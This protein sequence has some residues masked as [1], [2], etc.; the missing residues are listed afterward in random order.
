MD[1]QEAQTSSAVSGP[2]SV[3]VTNIGGIDQCSI[4]LKPGVNVLVGRNAT[5]RTSFLHAV[6][7]GLG[8][9]KPNLK[10]DA[11][12]GLVTLKADN[13]QY[14]R[15]QYRRNDTI[16]VEGNGYTT[17]SSLVDLFVATLEENPV[18]S[19][20]R[21]GDNLREI[22]MDPIDTEQINRR[23]RDLRR[24]KSDLES[25][26]QKVTQ[27][28]S[29]LPKL[30]E[31]RQ[32]LKSELESIDQ[33][34]E[35]HR[36]E[37]SEY[38]SDLDQTDNTEL[39]NRLENRRQQLN[40]A[41]DR[42]EVL[43][44]ELK[45]LNEKRDSLLEDEESLSG[46]SQGDLDQ[47]QRDLRSLRQ[48]KRELEGTISDLTTIV[49][50]N[51]NLIEGETELPDEVH[52]SDTT[53]DQLAPEEDRPVYCWTCG[54]ETT[55]GSIKS[56]LQSLRQIV[57]EKRDDRTS[58]EQ[59]INELQAEEKE[60]RKA[61]DKQQSIENNIDQTTRKI[62]EKENQVDQTRDRITALKDEVATLEKQVA[63]VEAVNED[64]ALEIHEK[65]SEL[66]YQRGQ[67]EEN[68]QR[69]EEDI[70]EIEALPDEEEILDQIG[71]IQD[72]LEDERARIRDIENEVV[73]EFNNHM[74]VILE[75]LDYQNIER[76][77]IERH[78]RDAEDTSSTFELHIVRTDASG[79][80]YEDSIENL[81]ESE[82]E[83]IGLILALAGFLAHEVYKDV[84]FILLDS[85]EAIDATRITN[86]VEYFAK[87]TEYL[88]VA[89]LPEDAG[90]ITGEANY[91]SADKLS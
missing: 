28:R 53:L 48:K 77:W 15:Q 2:L 50:F 82:R 46:R 38:Q 69:V 72:Q 51:D 6:A 71:Q 86:L 14:A 90:D 85:L 49:D 62:R 76:V 61:I 47:V 26:Q 21:R 58:I 68:L 17:K 67:V 87:Y 22:I 7:S 60:I 80:G 32:K 74:D 39:V 20:A 63:D 3:D 73:E 33:Q 83:V 43:E 44:A 8:G 91:I 78:V 30:E 37:L 57:Q 54:S 81:S 25:Q 23:I 70:N 36:T 31:R 29:Q 11:T 45:A 88:I 12:E 66:Q 89:L 59:Q 4:I 18:R 13:Q 65:I 52:P 16:H 27:R 34:I 56:Q 42:L 75:L 40:Q 84:P 64:A 24:N 79:A 19:A 35:S 41:K 55:I 10:S 1:N 5:N 9:N